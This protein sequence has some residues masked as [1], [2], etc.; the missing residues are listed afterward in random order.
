V[1]PV[2]AQGIAKPLQV[3]D[4]LILYYHEGAPDSETWES[5]N[6]MNFL[7]S[8]RELAYQPGQRWAENCHQQDVSSRKSCQPW[9]Y[10]RGQTGKHDG[11]FSM[12]YQS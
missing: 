4:R 5:T 3:Y 2:A 6:S 1:L 9:L 10:L 12:R 11:K 8:V 7:H